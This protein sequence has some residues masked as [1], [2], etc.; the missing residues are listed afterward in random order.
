MVSWSLVLS[1]T[2]TSWNY[3]I[4]IT[5][6]TFIRTSTPSGFSWHGGRDVDPNARICNPHP[7]HR[8]CRRPITQYPWWCTLA[9][10]PR[11]CASWTDLGSTPPCETWTAAQHHPHITED[12]HQLRGPRPLRSAED[13]WGLAHLSCRELAQI[14]TGN[15]LLLKGVLLACV[16]TFHGGATFLEHAAMPF[17]DE[18]WSIWRLGLVR[19]LHRPPHGPVRRISTQQW[20]FGSC[21][22]KPTTFLFSNIFQCKFIAVALDDCCDPE[23]VRPDQHLIGNNPDG[24]YRTSKAKEYPPLLNRAFATAIFAAMKHWQLAVGHTNNDEFGK[25]L[26]L[27]AVNTEYDSIC[28]DYQPKWAV[29]WR[30][31]DPCMAVRVRLICQCKEKC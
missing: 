7:V 13:L 26:A 15:I 4:L 23:A 16:A 10:S 9:I 28:P 20:K 11:D 18:I 30:L 1:G 27:M 2:W 12:G 31:W 24:S 25:N 5:S 22:V 6:F 14:Y 21:G 3:T 8:H 19:L 17:A 29:A